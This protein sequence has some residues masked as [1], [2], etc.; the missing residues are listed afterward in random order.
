MMLPR[1]RMFF[2]CIAIGALVV[3]LLANAH[4]VLVATNSQPRCVAHVKAGSEASPPGT[5]RAARSSC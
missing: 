5:F 2:I 4:L 1:S 3:V